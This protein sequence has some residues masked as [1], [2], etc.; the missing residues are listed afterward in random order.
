MDDLNILK[1]EQF[2][3]FKSLKLGFSYVK[4]YILLFLFLTVIVTTL[5][6]VSSSITTSIVM[7]NQP[8]IV[9]D[10]PNEK[11]IMDIYDVDKDGFEPE[12]ALNLI[13][14]ITSPA[15][16]TPFI[17]LFFAIIMISLEQCILSKI[18][19]KHWHKEDIKRGSK[20]YLT[21][22]IL[23]FIGKTALSIVFV[24]ICSILFAI[25][26][27][28][29]LFIVNIIL[30]LAIPIE[31]LSQAD[32]LTPITNC[33]FTIYIWLFSFEYFIV[34]NKMAKSLNNVQSRAIKNCKHLFGLF[35]ISAVLFSGFYYLGGIYEENTLIRIAISFVNTFIIYILYSS[36]VIK[37]MNLKYINN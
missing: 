5:T 34:G 21:K 12:E 25:I 33:L 15:L 4:K 17:T 9:K 2:N 30:E 24:F 36:F 6:E 8:Q 7:K 37:Y 28:I 13:N 1:T 22:V 16:F 35:L 29:I 20:Y 18:F 23:Y 32:F 14:D 31:N 11:N 19:F 10:N 26:L 3:T 27:F